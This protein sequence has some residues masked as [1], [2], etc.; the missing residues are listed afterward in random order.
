MTAEN[1]H[2]TN[3]SEVKCFAGTLKRFRHFSHVNQCEMT[4][5]IFLPH[6]VRRQKDNMPAL[7]WLSGL[8]CTDENFTQKAGAFRLASELGLV[9]VCPDTSPRGKAFPTPQRVNGNSA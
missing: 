5:S 8:T 1:N 2:I 6:Q 7:Y 3:V 4:F 9:I